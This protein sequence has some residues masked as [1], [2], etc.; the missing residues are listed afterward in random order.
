MKLRTRMT[1][2]IR[3]EPYSSLHFHLFLSVC[4]SDR[5]KTA[6][7]DEEQQWDLA[8][9][10]YLQGFRVHDWTNLERGMM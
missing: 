1:N 4:R 2:E 7:P 9:L 5:T 10:S 3:T 8:T 6:A